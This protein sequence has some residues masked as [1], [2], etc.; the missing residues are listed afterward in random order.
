M[1]LKILLAGLVLIPTAFAGELTVSEG[2]K[3]YTLN[4][5]AIFLELRDPSLKLSL[6]KKPCN[7]KM[8]KKFDSQVKLMFKRSTKQLSPISYGIKI[9]EGGKVFYT[10]LNTPAGKFFHAIP[11]EFKRLKVEESLRCGKAL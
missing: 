6:V 2:L 10:T 8:I 5:S 7:E 9:S 4:H 1:F 11:E 3:T